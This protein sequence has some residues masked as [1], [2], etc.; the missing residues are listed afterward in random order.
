MSSELIGRSNLPPV[1]TKKIIVDELEN[2]IKVEYFVP[3]LTD[4]MDNPIWHYD[5]FVDKPI[6]IYSM[7]LFSPSPANDIFSWHEE[8]ITKFKTNIYDLFKGVGS[9]VESA[10]AGRIGTVLPGIADVPHLDGMKGT[11]RIKLT[12]NSY[13][14]GYFR[15]P[16]V[17]EE[18]FS[19]LYSPDYIFKN[20]TLITFMAYEI[21][22][23]DDVLADRKLM[24]M[25]HAACDIIKKDGQYQSSSFLLKKQS[26]GSIY[27][28]PVHTHVIDNEI[29]TGP[30]HSSDSESLFVENQPIN[31]KLKVIPDFTNISPIT[32]PNSNFTMF[33][34]H[35]RGQFMNEA[36]KQDPL[37]FVDKKVNGIYQ[38]QALLPILT[39]Y[40]LPPQT[41]A[42]GGSFLGINSGGSLINA[43]HKKL[44]TNITTTVTVSNGIGK[45][46]IP[47]ESHPVKILNY[48][49]YSYL[50]INADSATAPETVELQVQY[51]DH[52]DLGSY[53][54]IL[55]LLYESGSSSVI[56]NFLNHHDETYYQQFLSLLTRVLS[57][58]S[59]ENVY[60]ETS[61]IRNLIIL[62]GSSLSGT[63]DKIYKEKLV[64]LFQDIQQRIQNAWPTEES[65]NRFSFQKTFQKQINIPKNTNCEFLTEEAN[66]N[67]YI[68]VDDLEVHLQEMSNKLD[69]SNTLPA[70]SVSLSTTGYSRGK[71]SVTPRSINSQNINDYTNV[72]DSIDPSQIKYY[73]TEYQSRMVY[74]D[75]S[76]DMVANITFTSNT[77][78]ETE[79]QPADNFTPEEIPDA[80]QTMN[81]GGDFGFGGGSGGSY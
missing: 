20:L 33:T 19:P 79:D 36:F 70:A 11:Q 32:D 54:K 75:H 46:L 34:S 74:E 58:Y 42:L 25:G 51:V 44:I 60:V 2:S 53:N 63:E 40:L 77:P 71:I 30:V 8:Q 15:G 73:D 57:I 65:K 39:N 78:D 47:S 49:G 3:K 13:Y 41:V 68:T 55:N 27:R 6:Y 16:K 50:L 18:Y 61:T 9:E 80:E 12:K 56:N 43:N 81:E 69:V 29:M 45:N 17:G 52:T 76:A 48:A 24:Y 72:S 10:K 4:Q 26:D 38:I 5:S 62:I 59:E 21:P 7:L 22:G 64:S 1:Y 28:G 35:S 37:I 66:G 14:N 31:P 67:G 23:F